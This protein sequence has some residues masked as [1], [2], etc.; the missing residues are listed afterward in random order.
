MGSNEGSEVM[1]YIMSIIQEGKV[2]PFAE[3][4]AL[5]H[6]MGMKVDEVSLTKVVE[7]S[8]EKNST[9]EKRATAVVIGL[10][11][12]MGFD[13][14]VTKILAPAKKGYTNPLATKAPEYSDESL[15]I[16]VNQYS[17]F[18]MLGMAAS[19]FKQFKAMIEAMEKSMGP[20]KETSEMMKPPIVDFLNKYGVREAFD[21]YMHATILCYGFKKEVSPANVAPILVTLGVKTDPKRLEKTCA[22]VSKA[23]MPELVKSQIAYLKAL[24]E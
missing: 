21:P 13:P 20:G 8:G 14:S 19:A 15:K 22:L 2:D 9:G 7:S 1:G 4:I 16:G 18:I 23:N 6:A 24:G 5:L 17:M 12:E 11:N 3:G 10:Y